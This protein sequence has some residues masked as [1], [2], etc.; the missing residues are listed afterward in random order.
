MYRLIRL[1]NISGGAMK[2]TA[3]AALRIDD[4]VKAA[5][6]DIC[7]IAARTARSQV[8]LIVEYA[9][10]RSALIRGSVGSNAGRLGGNISIPGLHHEE[11]PL[12]ICDDLARAEWFR[13]HPLRKLVPHASSLIALSID[14][15]SHGTSG[16]LIVLNPHPLAARDAAT[17]AALSEL[18]RISGFILSGDRPREISAHRNGLHSGS[19]DRPESSGFQETNPKDDGLP[20]PIHDPLATF[21]FRTLVPRRLLRSR[22]SAHYVTLRSWKKS[23]K[24]TQIA[25]LR[26]LKLQLPPKAVAAIAAE[27]AVAVQDLYPGIMFTA[28]VPVPCG[29]SGHQRC[30]SFQLAQE[31]SKA[32]GVQLCR[33]LSSSGS[34]GTS[35]PKQSARLT[36][37]E[38]EEAVSGQVLLVDDVVTSGQ[39]IELAMKALRSRG[40]IPL[41]IAW[42]GG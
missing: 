5:C 7:R 9:N 23:V 1:G 21:L 12:I 34:A 24:D 14:T 18:A 13:D 3:A 26:S 4:S 36:K 28:V 19:E 31:V 32:L 38:V 15:S 10:K 30:L 39:H 25:A 42:I 16:A 33:A 22:K 2:S 41:A 37:F 40:A 8:A 20:L 27:I 17:G 35:H 11:Q 6:D 29:S